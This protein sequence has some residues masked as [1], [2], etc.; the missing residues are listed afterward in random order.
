M[1]HP[2]ILY[3]ISSIVITLNYLIRIGLIL[4]LAGFWVLNCLDQD[5]LDFR[6]NRILDA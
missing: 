3:V 2:F 6:M 4:G 5:L 1:A